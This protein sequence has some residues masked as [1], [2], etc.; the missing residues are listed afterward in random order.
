MSLVET[1]CQQQKETLVL[2]GDRQKSHPDAIDVCQT[3]GSVLLPAL[4]PDGPAEEWQ[5]C[6]GGLPGEEGSLVVQGRLNT[7][8]AP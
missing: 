6:A 5:L 3:Q 2:T 4:C 8:F 1:S 7:H